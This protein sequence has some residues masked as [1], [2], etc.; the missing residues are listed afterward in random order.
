MMKTSTFIGK[1]I[2]K[3][4]FTHLVTVKPYGRFKHT[5]DSICE[6]FSKVD[7]VQVLYGTKERIQSS[8]DSDWHYHL[9]IKADEGFATEMIMS[10][11]CRVSSGTRIK[12]M[13]LVNTKSTV[14]FTD[15][16]VE[17]EYVRINRNG[18]DIYIE[19]IHSIENISFYISKFTDYGILTFY[20]NYKS[21]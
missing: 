21:K 15:T 20:Q 13:K 12:V 6:L 4:D 5:D 17:V 14:G 1:N 7:S 10:G 8:A 3:L 18:L 11:R 9:L 19:P 2:G 16:Y